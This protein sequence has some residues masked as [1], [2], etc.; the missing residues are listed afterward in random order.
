MSWRSFD[1]LQIDTREVLQA[2]GT[3]WNFLPFQPG[4]VAGIA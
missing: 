4:L 3:K 1:R 2:A